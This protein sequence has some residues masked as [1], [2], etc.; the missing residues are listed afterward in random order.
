MLRL[1]KKLRRNERGNVLLIAAFSMPLIVGSAGLAVDTIQWAL[2]KRQIQRA[3]DSAALAGV[4]AKIQG[5]TGEAAAETSIAK[6]QNTGLTLATP[7]YPVPQTGNWTNAFRVRLSTTQNPSFSSQFIP[8]ITIPAEATAATIRTGVYCV[9][10]LV[11]TAT[12]GITATG[13]GDIRLG[14][15]M[16]TNSTSMS[17]AI[18]TGSSD[19]FANSC[20]GSRIGPVEQQLERRGA[21]ALYGQARRPIR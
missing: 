5:Q 1:L 16:I 13:N 10:S 9:V 2:W 7:T 11:N 21:L 20:R 6:F 15:G 18:A 4:Y 17:A 3:A 19:V 8:S 12:T 14:C